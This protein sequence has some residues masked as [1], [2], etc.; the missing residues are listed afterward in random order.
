MPH[1][2]LYP[3]YHV[4]ADGVQKANPGWFQ[5]LEG[6]GR[7]RRPY[8]GHRIERVREI[9]HPNLSRSYSAAADLSA[10]KKSCCRLP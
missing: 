2:V 10:S 5:N 6:L 3:G 7:L 9:C 8:S 4:R 1:S